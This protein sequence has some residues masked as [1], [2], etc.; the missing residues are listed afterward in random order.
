MLIAAVALTAGFIYCALSSGCSLTSTL[1]GALSETAYSEKDLHVESIVPQK[2]GTL[3]ITFTPLIETMYFCPGANV[4]KSAEG[5]EISFVRAA[6]N[7]RPKV[8]FPGKPIAK[9]SNSMRIDVP[10]Q[11]E[12]L[13]LRNGDRLV[14]LFPRE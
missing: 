14:K 1:T 6:M 3:Q 13:F 12:T 8:D 9:T 5:L 11:G 10:A 4:K 7:Q 2:D